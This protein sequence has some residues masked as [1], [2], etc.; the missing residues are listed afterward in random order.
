M[1]KITEL[2]LTESNFIN[3][4]VR[5]EDDKALAGTFLMGLIALQFSMITVEKGVKNENKLQQV[6][7]TIGVV[8][9]AAMVVNIFYM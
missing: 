4:G 3:G 6:I 8:S 1:S 9:A 5:G 7:G 2:S